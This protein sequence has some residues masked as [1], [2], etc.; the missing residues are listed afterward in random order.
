MMKSLMPKGL[1]THGNMASQIKLNLPDRNMADIII[2]GIAAKLNASGD[3]IV[4]YINSSGDLYQKGD[5]EHK[6]SFKLSSLRFQ[7]LRILK[8]SFVKPEYIRHETDSVSVG[9]VRKAVNEINSQVKI[10]LGIENNII[11]GKGGSGY[12]INPKYKLEFI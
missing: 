5:Q 4:L 1:V 12:R 3:K 10:K 9:S 7:I 6:H 2:D 8:D 11:E